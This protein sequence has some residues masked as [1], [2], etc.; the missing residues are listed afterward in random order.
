MTA[1]EADSGRL[2]GEADEPGW[3]VD[4]DD[5]W[6]VAVIA[7][8]GRQLK[9]RREAVGMRA[10]EFGTAVGYGEDMV[11]KIEGGKRIPR[12]DYLVRADEVLGAG[13]L[14]AAT[15]EDVKKVR[16]PKKVRE[17][18]KLEGQAVEIGVYECNSVHGLLQTPEH[19]RALFEAA[20]PPYSPDDVERMVAARMA[21]QSV[22]E[23][24][25]APSVHYVLEEAVLRRRVGGTMVWRQQLERLL[26]LG[27]LRNVALQ[28]MPTN[29]DAHPGVG[30]KIELLKF[31]DGTA[32]GRS[33]GAFSGRPTTDPKQLRI[34]ELRYGTIRA[35]A[36]APRESL[37]F[38]EHV[39]GET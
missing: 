31:P 18:A 38:I 17:L 14:L 26:E 35:Q 33:E 20:Q 32:V 23:R 29:S 3:E 10:G 28:V 39:L 24:D 8:V 6:G 22:F 4:P 27:R 11:Y 16:Y 9:L 12:Q 1:V 7:T 15:W 13:G 37:A 19:A 21:R 30:G 36:L 2:K 5:E 34:L 25:P